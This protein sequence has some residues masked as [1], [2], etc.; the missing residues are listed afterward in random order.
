MEAYRT[1]NYQK[2]KHVMWYKVN[3]LNA[4]G[5]NFTQISH[6]TGLHRQTVS[7]YV[8]MSESEFLSSQ[9]YRRQYNRVL[10]VYTD[11][12]RESLQECPYLSAAQIEDWLCERFDDF[13]AVS[14]KTVYNFVKYVRCKYG[15]VKGSGHE[16]R[17]YSKLPDTAYGDYAQVDFGEQWMKRADGRQVKV[18]FFVM[19]L[20]RSRQKFVYLN[21]SPFTTARTIYAHEL[22]FAY[23]GGKP[24]K[25]IYDQDK[26]LISDEHLGDVVLTG[27]FS[28]F[29]AREHLQ[30]V[31]CRKADPESKGKVENAVKYVKYN[32]LRGRTFHDIERLQQETLAWLDR[33]GNGTMNGSTYRIPK[34]VFLEEQ[35]YLEPYH[36]V[37]AE[38]LEQEIKVHHVRKDNTVQ[39][40]GSFYTVPLGTYRGANTRVWLNESDGRLMVYSNESG[41]VMA[42]HSLTQSRGQ[43]V[44]I[45]AHLKQRYEA[46]DELEAHILAWV[47]DDELCRM[48]IRRLHEKK[49]RYYIDN[50]RL[51]VKSMKDYPPQIM[52]QAL[53][54]CLDRGAYNARMLMETARTIQL[55]KT[56]RI[57]NRISADSL[58]EQAYIIPEK[59]S[60]NQF[61]SLF[62]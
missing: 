10:D 45:Q 2:T 54:M 50:L 5:L 36:G 6:H 49:R 12:V 4:K 35:P 31:F 29:V 47:G 20:S 41:K 56:A 48:W 53:L 39:Y 57:E 8:G 18:Y 62:E 15:L 34:E 40:R 28:A 25:I 3:E 22:A 27:K 58:P 23:Y 21:Q 51:L 33:T 16:P 1:H 42:I 24:R 9:S 26:V 44:R 60:I 55:R 46:D 30:V 52:H 7:R 59:T 38:P 43:L 17:A 13:P 61:K 32:F 11:F 19:V 14:S 37:P